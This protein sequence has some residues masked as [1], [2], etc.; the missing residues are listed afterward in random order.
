MR[1]SR[2]AR[3]ATAGLGAGHERLT[4]RSAALIIIA[5]SA[6]SWAMLIGIAAALLQL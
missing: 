1:S 5:A 2:L 6:L 4:V 3:P